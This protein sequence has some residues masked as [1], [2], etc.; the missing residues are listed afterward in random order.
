M[1]SIVH[2]SF[3]L[4]VFPFQICAH[5]QS[6]CFL[7]MSLSLFFFFLIRIICNFR[8]WILFLEPS[9]FS[10]TPFQTFSLWDHLFW[11]F[12]NLPSSSL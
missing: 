1:F 5:Q 8:F 4:C 11:T 12:W 9:Y 6:G 3:H 7:W 10:P 2:P